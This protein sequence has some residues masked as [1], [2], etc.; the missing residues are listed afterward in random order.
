[1]QEYPSRLQRSPSVNGEAVLEKSQEGWQRE[2]QYW[3]ESRKYFLNLGGNTDVAFALSLQ[4]R[5]FLM[6]VK[7]P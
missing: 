7:M 3:T 2:F 5:A 1:M 6:L 4:L